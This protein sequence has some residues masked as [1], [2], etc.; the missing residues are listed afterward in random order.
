LFVMS[1]QLNKLGFM[2]FLG[3]RLVMRLGGLPP[4]V[5]AVTLLVVYVAIHYLFVSQTAHLLALFAVFLGVGAKLGVSAPLLAFQLLFA[6]N[7]FAAL[8][9]QSSS[10]NLLFVG[11]RLLSAGRPLQAGAP[12]TPRLHAAV[13]RDRDTVAAPGDPLGDTVHGY[14]LTALRTNPELAIFLT[15]ACGFVLGSVKIGSFQARQRGRHAA[16]RRA[17]RAARHSG[18]TVVKVV[19]FDLFLFATDTRSAR[20]SSAVWAERAATGRA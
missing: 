19:F 8:A 9:P 3:E 18:P 7:Y 1:D 17:D 15:L 20:S 12:S 5:V 4:A 13:P 2:E 10:A 11:Q 16:R 6:T 14:F